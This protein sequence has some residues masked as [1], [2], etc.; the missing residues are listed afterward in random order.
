MKFADFQ[1]HN[2]ET[3]VTLGFPF[4]MAFL[5]NYSVTVFKIRNGWT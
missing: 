4:I 1:S 2:C 5:G 3:F